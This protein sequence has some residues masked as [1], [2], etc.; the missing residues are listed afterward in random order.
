MGVLGPYYRQKFDSK[1]HEKFVGRGIVSSL[2]EYI[3]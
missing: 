1:K 3:G 2:L